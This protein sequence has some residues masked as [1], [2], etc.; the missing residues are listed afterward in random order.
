MLLFND[1]D[2]AKKAKHLTTQAKVEHPWE[3]IHDDIGYN[4]RMPNI[5]AAL[6]LAQLEQLDVF[7]ERKRA[8]ADIYAEFFRSLEIQFFTEPDMA[9]SNYWLNVLLL[10]DS[11]ER[12]EFLEKTNNNNIKTRPAWKLMSDLPMF[13]GCQKTSL[14]NATFLQDRLVN[15]PS[16][17]I[18][19]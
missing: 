6:G 18:I 11:V 19:K 10:N 1:E 16:S 9:R 14:A 12:N 8:L 13:T 5:N 2:L 7:I 4:Y 17:V 15:I 3:F